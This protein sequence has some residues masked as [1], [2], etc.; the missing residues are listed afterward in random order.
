MASAATDSSEAMLSA[1]EKAWRCIRSSLVVVPTLGLS[2][3]QRD[4]ASMV[5]ES[6]GHSALMF[7][8]RS[9]H[10]DHGDLWR[11]AFSRDDLIWTEITPSGTLPC[12]RSGHTAVMTNKGKMRVFG[13]FGGNEFLNDTMDYDTYSQTWTKVDTAGKEIVGRRGHAAVWCE[14]KMYVY[15]GQSLKE[16]PLDELLVL[17]SADRIGVD[18]KDWWRVIDFDNG[19]GALY[20]LNAFRFPQEDHHI[21][22]TAGE[23]KS[24]SSSD[25]IWRFDV[26]TE[27]FSLLPGKVDAR[28]RH[29]NVPLD[30]RQILLIG[31]CSDNP[32]EYAKPAVQVY[33]VATN[34]S[35]TLVIDQD[36]E[37]ERLS[38]RMQNAERSNSDSTDV[39]TV[40]DEK[41]NSPVW[42]LKPSDA[43]RRDFCVVALHDGEMYR[44]LIW[45]G[46]SA[47]GYCNP[48]VL[49]LQNFVYE[50]IPAEE[51]EEDDDQLLSYDDGA[52]IDSDAVAM[53]D[54]AAFSLDS[55]HEELM[56][57]EDAQKILT[58]PGDSG[59]DHHLSFAGSVAYASNLSAEDKPKFELDPQSPSTLS[60][61]VPTVA[62]SVASADSE[63]GTI[64]N[65]P[66][67]SP[68]IGSVT[69]SKLPI[70]DDAGTMTPSSRVDISGIVTMTPQPRVAPERLEAFQ[71]EME[72]ADLR[73]P[74]RNWQRGKLLGTGA[75][76]NVYLCLDKDSGEMFASKRVN[77]SEHVPTNKMDPLIKELSIL[78]RLHHPN[79]VSFLGFEVNNKSVYIFLEY[80][81][82]GDLRTVLKAFGG[83]SAAVTAK[84]TNEILAG[85]HYLHSNR[86]IH[87]DIKGANVLLT[88]QGHCKLG[89]FGLA[90]AVATMGPGTKSV[91][92]SPYWMAPEVVRG[93]GAVLGSDIWSL[94]ATVFEMATAK[95]PFSHL[96]STAALFH[97]GMSGALVEPLPESL[98]AT[99]QDFIKQC[100]QIQPM[101]RPTTEALLNHAFLTEEHTSSAPSS[102]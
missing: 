102:P 58:P 74:A 100:M 15:G 3:E 101:K 80:C 62:V 38:K 81:G 93:L 25:A 92:G 68:Y 69:D 61:N 88:A 39:A 75:Y 37:A 13:G 40:I 63:E 5:P 44:V 51:S 84:Y 97:I 76:G 10:A 50:S 20:D 99:G 98:G 73:S 55:I 48:A 87:R 56:N 6:E 34:E 27:N 57:I 4:G 59:S 67:R 71:K 26:Q 64:H 83:L 29:N 96:E 52:D 32:N 90:K 16:G 2:P 41:F 79:V 78:R 54:S 49:A 46:R 86:V 65:S 31:G 14:S 77:I 17:E 12:P 36:A 42:V 95:P 82:G 47:K 9:Y 18:L 22:F 11:L 43:E 94:G 53:A 45:G 30:E 8:G 21:Y 23:E 33:N 28:S 70:Y 60:D 1:Q 66:A 7:G 24:F 19:P 72:S 35:H 89:D 91:A 85:L